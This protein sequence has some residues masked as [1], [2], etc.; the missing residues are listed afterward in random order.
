[1][2]LPVPHLDDRTFDQLMEEAHRQVHTLCPSWTD[3]TPGDPGTT[4]LEV[5]AYLTETML[6]RLNRVPEKAYVEFLRLLGVTLTPP[7]AASTY[8]RF[9]REQPATSPVDVPRG[10]RVTLG[11]ESA[12]SDAPIFVTASVAT[13]GAGETEVRVLAHHADLVEGELAGTGTGRPGQT[14][15]ARRPPIVSPTGD[16]LDLVVGIETDPGALPE[17]TRALE[18]SGKAYRV[19]REVE[20]FVGLEEDDRHVYV[21]DRTSGTITFAPSVRMSVGEGH[22]EEAPRALAE[23]V[24]AGAEIRLWY[25]RGGGPEGNVPPDTLTTL[26]DPVRGLEVTNP[27]AATGGREVETLEN[28]LVRGPQEL[29]SLRRTVTARDYELVAI[30]SA[31]AVARARAFTKSAIWEH[32]PPG[33]VEVAL[34]PRIPDPGRVTRDQLLERQTD[35]ALERIEDALAARRPLGTRCEVT[36]ARY[37]P[38]SVKA[39]IVVYREEDPEAVKARVLE[40]LYQ[41]VNPLPTSLGGGGWRFGEA[42][43]VSHIFEMVLREPGVSYVDRVKLEVGE[44]PDRDISVVAVDQ[45]QRS[46]GGGIEHP[47]GTWYVGKDETVYRSLNDG[48]GW[49]VAGRFEGER[50]H[51]IGSHPQRPGL[52]AAVTT[53]ED[54]GGQKAAIHVSWDCGESWARHGRLGFRVYDAEW[55]LRDGREVLLLASDVGLYEMG[56]TEP[57][58]VQIVVDPASPEIGFYAV[59]AATDARGA[60]TVAVGTEEKKGVFVSSQGAAPDTFRHVGLADRDIRSLAVQHAGP[61]TFLWAGAWAL[62]PDDEGDG[63]SRMRL[64]GW[65]DEVEGT[66]DVE[67]WEHF[68]TGW[69]GGSCYSLAVTDTTVLAGTH[70]AG[71]LTLDAAARSPRWTAPD[72]DCNLPLHSVGRF[73]PIDTLA[74]RPGLF[75]VGGA[76]G[77]YRSRDG[78]TRYEKVSSREFTEAVTLPETWLFCSSEHEVEVVGEDDAEREE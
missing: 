23:V 62:G 14:V 73:H 7:S 61:I 77:V 66:E 31:G 2:P 46:R 44:A 1:M 60:V 29:H 75:M 37:K 4:I 24:P 76:E 15:V 55:I 17:L 33:T 36:W 59:T 22:L 74:A 8:L 30:R 10:T 71:V 40:R 18:W 13:I 51:W 54:D 3:L 63:C 5:F 65:A 67:R 27:E 57:N 25:R 64:R 6:Y 50:V 52:L 41:L 38:V 16:D 68:A 53:V 45:H 9:Y 49:E 69:K 47:K 20:Q 39:R 43:R 72:L 56:A 11:R 32:A 70:R 28:A 12:D 42:L 35:D 19:W 48:A 78:G 34:V 21:V 26:K 58:P